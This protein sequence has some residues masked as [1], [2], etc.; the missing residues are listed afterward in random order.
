MLFTGIV[1]D[2]HGTSSKTNNIK[3][4][5]RVIKGNVTARGKR[6]QGKSMYIR[7]ENPLKEV[8]VIWRV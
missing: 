4:I 7:K 1:I 3:Y 8:R 6:D 5:E 2:G